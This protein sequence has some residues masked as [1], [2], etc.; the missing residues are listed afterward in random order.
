MSV[1]NVSL[2]SGDDR[3]RVA[4]EMAA[5]LW[6]NETGMNPKM[7]DKTFFELVHNCWRCVGPNGPG[8]FDYT[9]V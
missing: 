7:S 5:K 4:Y 9:G 2:N 6:F 1:E 8:N 3:A